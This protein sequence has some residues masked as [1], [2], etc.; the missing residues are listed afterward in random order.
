MEKDFIG[1][2]IEES[3]ENPRV[4]KKLKILN[5]KVERVT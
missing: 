3:L 2:I 4:L 1:T 5:T